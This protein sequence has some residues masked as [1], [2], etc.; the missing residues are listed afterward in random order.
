[1]KPRD[2]QVLALKLVSETGA[3]ELRSSVS[4]AYYAVYNSAVEMVGK[5]GFHVGSGVQ[6]H[7]DVQKWLGNSGDVEIKKVGSKLTNLRTK[8]NRADYELD[9]TDVENPRTVQAVIQ[10]SE[11]MLQSLEQCLQE[12]VRCQRIREEI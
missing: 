4:R 9:R 5:L 6:G 12:P 10:D 2:F 11:S 8:R 3:A 1:M 7:G